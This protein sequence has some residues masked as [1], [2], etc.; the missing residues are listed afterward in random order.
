VALQSTPKQQSSAV[1]SEFVKLDDVTTENIWSTPEGNEESRV[2]PRI[3]K[4]R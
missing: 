2:E 4:L 1:D 3:P